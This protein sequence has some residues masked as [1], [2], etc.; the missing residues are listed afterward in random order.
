MENII[1]TL[2]RLGQT[3]GFYGL[4]ADWRQIV[5]IVI[6]CVLLYLGLVKKF[7]PLLLVG[8]AFG[9]LL[10]NLPFGNMY[11]PELWDLY[12]ANGQQVST[13]SPELQ[14]FIAEHGLIF[15]D[16]I[17]QMSFTELIH[18]GAL[19]DIMYI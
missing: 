15:A 18:A 13:L 12:I 8:I 19:L 7:E 17:V 9:M 16:G 5:M 3:S 2:G 4:F 1:A 10:T 14:A 6:A 11:N